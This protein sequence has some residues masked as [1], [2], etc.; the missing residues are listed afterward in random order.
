[1]TWNDKYSSNTNKALRQELWKRNIKPDG[2]QRYSVTKYW[3]DKKR[4]LYFEDRKEELQNF[5]LLHFRLQTSNP[6][7]ASKVIPL[8]SRNYLF[9]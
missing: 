5:R 3:T 6:V 7:T 8:L 2:K 4:K 9:L 1:M